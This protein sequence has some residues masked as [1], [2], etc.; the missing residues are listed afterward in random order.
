MVKHDED[1]DDEVNRPIP[2][3]VYFGGRY[4]DR[5]YW[6]FLGLFALFFLQIYVRKW[7]LG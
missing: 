5:W 1:K 6:V 3:V 4:S 2:V 7:L